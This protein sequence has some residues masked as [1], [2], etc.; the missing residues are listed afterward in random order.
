ME[1]RREGKSNLKDA[2]RDACS[3]LGTH[4]YLTLQAMPFRWLLL[5]EAVAGVDIEGE[6]VWAAEFRTPV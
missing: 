5:N 3:G 6:T 2:N 1:S 4:T